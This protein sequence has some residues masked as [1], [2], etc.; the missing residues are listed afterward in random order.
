MLRLHNSGRRGSCS[1]RRGHQARPSVNY[2]YRTAKTAA[3]SAG[4]DFSVNFPRRHMCYDYT[5]QAAVAA[6]QADVVTKQGLA[7]TARTA[8]TAACLAGIDFSVNFC[9]RLRRCAAAGQHR[10]T[11]HDCQ[12]AET[13]RKLQR[14]AAEAAISLPISRNKCLFDTKPHCTRSLIPPSNSSNHLLLNEMSL[15]YISVFYACRYFM[16]YFNSE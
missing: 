3:C 6:A 4:I 13:A 9:R 16:T 14:L 2:A 11:C 5:S 10:N 1:S 12:P 15:K 8:K 7:S